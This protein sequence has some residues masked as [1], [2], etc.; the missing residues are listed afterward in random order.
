MYQAQGCP[1]LLR[2]IWQ[3]L[4]TRRPSRPQKK[5]SSV[6]KEKYKIPIKAKIRYF[7]ARCRRQPCSDERRVDIDLV[8]LGPRRSPSTC[9]ESRGQ[10]T[11]AAIVAA[12]YG[13]LLPVR[14]CPACDVHSPGVD[15][16]LT[17]G[18]AA[19]ERVELFLGHTDLYDVAVEACPPAQGAN[20]VSRCFACEVHWEGFSCD[21]SA[22]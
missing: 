2:G 20:H 9:S 5:S 15:C 7:T 8:E 10:P 11:T 12:K 3:G 14:Y 17:N 16:A 21:W 19:R 22:L 6:H 13:I 18:E 4:T 1:A